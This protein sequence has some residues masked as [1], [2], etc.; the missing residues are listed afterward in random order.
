MVL[1]SNT[2]HSFYILY[3]RGMHSLSGLWL[4]SGR[5]FIYGTSWW[6]ILII[7]LCASP[8]CTI[9]MKD[10]RSRV[11]EVNK[12]RFVKPQKCIWFLKKK[13]FTHV[14][15]TL[16]GSSAFYYLVFK[17]R[18]QNGS[19]FIPLYKELGVVSLC[20]CWVWVQSRF[21]SGKTTFCH[22]GNLWRPDLVKIL[23]IK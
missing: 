6:S 10:L 17:A 5:S 18:S 8:S 19:F 9:Y 4:A 15:L 21:D 12:C 2:F 1:L 22:D 11:P 16:F 20:S 23:P 14:S 13:Y 7:T 3:M